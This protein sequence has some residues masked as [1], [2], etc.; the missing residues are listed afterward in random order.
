MFTFCGITRSGSIDGDL[1]SKIDSKAKL[2]PTDIG[3]ADTVRDAKI[4]LIIA[5]PLDVS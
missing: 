3:K 5:V 4:S 1:A 2:V